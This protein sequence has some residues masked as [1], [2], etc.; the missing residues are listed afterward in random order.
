M[1]DTATF[2]RLKKFREAFGDSK[3]GGLV[4]MNNA[5][6]TPLCAPARK[7]L[8]E[9][10][11][12][13]STRAYHGEAELFERFRKAR[14]PFARLLGV[15][16]DQVAM[17]ASCAAA[18]SMV[19]LG[20]PLRE[21]DE[22]LAWDQEY[23]SNVYPW[24][25]AARRS[26]ALYKSLTSGE[27]MELD[28]DRLIS[29]IT[30]RTKVVAISW[31]QFQSGALTPLREVAQ[32]C[33]R[34]GAWLVVDVI[35]GLGVLP[36]DLNSMGVDVVCAGT[37]KWL[38]G[39][40]GHGFFA[41]AREHLLSLRPVLQGAM[42]Y[43]GPAEPVQIG[44]E[45][46]KSA[47]RYEPGSP[48]IYGTFAGAAA[49]ELILETGVDTLSREALRLSTRLARAAV[50]LG[51]TLVGQ[52]A[53]NMQSP[54]TTIRMRKGSDQVEAFAHELGE[55]K[56]SF[57]RRAGG[58]RLSPHAFNTDSEIDLAIEAIQRASRV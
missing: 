11:H 36:F 16:R 6:I 23:P 34:Q 5:G 55:R 33:H 48:A 15:E 32:A 45:P 47:L 51:H 24:H 31:V 58:L 46:L 1:Q 28:P 39:I 18:I 10:A 27:R 30:P 8:L 37:H 14:D 49:I 4:H 20:M 40:L 9:V 12:W 56:I 43:G 41:M 54:I 44:K 17:T 21:G 57:A 35:Q 50:E 26:G 3:S 53:E 2:E 7:A 25:E 52:E 19:A 22:I 38:C 13:A 29:A 42:T